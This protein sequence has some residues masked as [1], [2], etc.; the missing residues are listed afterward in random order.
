MYKRKTSTYKKLAH[1][2]DRQ[3]RTIFIQP[4]RQ[5][6]DGDPD[7]E[8]QTGEMMMMQNVNF[9]DFATKRGQVKTI[10]P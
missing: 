1:W 9:T 6:P 7:G 10:S 2:N 8:W 4:H 5:Q 3:K